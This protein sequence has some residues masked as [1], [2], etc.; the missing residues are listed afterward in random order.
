MEIFR[1]AEQGADVVF[2]FYNNGGKPVRAMAD[3]ENL[4]A[5]FRHFFHLINLHFL[6]ESKVV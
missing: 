1:Q 4:H 5:N 3:A 6:S 2:G